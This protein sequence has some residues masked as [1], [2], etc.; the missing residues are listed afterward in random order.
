MIEQLLAGHP[1]I[2]YISVA[3]QRLRRLGVMGR[4]NGSVYGAAKPGTGLSRLFSPSE[5]YDLLAE[6]ASAI[7]T[8][9]YRDPT[10]E[11]VTPA[12]RR[13]VESFFEDRAAAQ[14]KPVFMHRFTGWPR[15]S[16]LN[17]IFPEALF[18]HIV[19]DGRAVAASLLRM[20]WWRGYEGPESWGFGELSAEDSEAWEA[21]G[22]S[23][24]VLAALEWKI[25]MSAF[26]KASQSVAGERWHE[27]K[28]E[29]FVSSPRDHLE[30]M[31]AF[32]G[33]SWNR[34]FGQF[35][36]R[37]DVRNDAEPDY[38]SVFGG[39]LPL[40]EAAIR[41]QLEMAGYLVS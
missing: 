39:E 31:L 21:A 8:R 40:V 23:F 34:R 6:Q 36:D 17:E 11:D 38:G 19:R 32:M 9:P 7:L 5:P 25:L 22:R 16:L 3:D 26:A 18:V 35:V 41:D 13:G 1:D 14:G 20:S 4:F 29:D 30:A 2:G 15:V 28:Y 12:L 37:F 24:P 33:L 10:A 27:I